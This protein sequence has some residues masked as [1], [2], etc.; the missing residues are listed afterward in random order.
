MKENNKIE[1]RIRMLENF[2]SSSE[3]KPMRFRDIVAI[4]QVPKGE[5]KE[6]KELLIPNK[7]RKIFSMTRE[8]TNTWGYDKDR[9]ILW[10]S[11]G[12]WFRSNRR[13]KGYL[14]T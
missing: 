3:Y 4:L 8:D 10:N 13:K 11:K 9:H 7:P 6:L 14:Y 12:L 2:F 5:N 1:E